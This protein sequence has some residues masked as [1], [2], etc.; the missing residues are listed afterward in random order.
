MTPKERVKRAIEFKHPDQI[1]VF[2]DE[3]SDVV[4]LSYVDP[5]G[6]APR[7]RPHGEFKDEW[8][9]VWYTQDETQGHVRRPAIANIEEAC[10]FVTPD[11]H[12]PARWEVLDSVIEAHRD[13]YIVGNA[14]YLLYDRL[15]FLLGQTSVLEGLLLD[16]DTLKPLMDRIIDFEMAIVDEM[17][18][19]EVDGI[20]FWDDI[21]AAHGVIMGPKTWRAVLAPYY[22]RIF[23]HI[24][25]RG[26]DVHWHSCGHCVDVMED[27][28]EMGADVFSI[29]E[30]FMMS[31]K[32]LSDSFKGRVCFE[33]SPDN[34]SV[35]S[36]GNEQDIKKA[37][38]QL[39]SALGG[40]KGG[41]ILVAAADNF[42]CLPSDTRRIVIDAAL[43][44]RTA[45]YPS[46]RSE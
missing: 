22:K 38:D 37:L 31:L 21:G 29:G 32:K 41:L 25:E 46:Y 17:A 4:R 44:A 11:P 7:N 34:R 13:Q 9:S 36:K 14:Q 19:R 8:G 20:R 30:P 24:H 3:Q 33:C 39:I 40:P 18:D 12:L 5:T 43:R 42:D 35:L 23:T 15:T 1:P 2:S 28:I 26:L 16:V 6:W 10:K 45:G 27:L